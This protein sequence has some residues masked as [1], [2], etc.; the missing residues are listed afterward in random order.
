[1][2][3]ANWRI[4]GA[5]MAVSSGLVTIVLLACSGDDSGGPTGPDAASSQDSSTS[6]ASSR[7]TSTSEASSG[8]SASIQDVVVADSPADSAKSNDGS[9]EADASLPPIVPLA[10]CGILDTDWG[11]SPPVTND[12]RATPGGWD[13]SGAGGTVPFTLAEALTSDCEMYGLV[14]TFNPDAGYGAADYIDQVASFTVQFLGCGSAEAGSPSFTGL[15]PTTA[16]GTAYVWTRAD[17]DR[18]A[19]MYSNAIVEAASF[20]WTITDFNNGAPPSDVPLTDD[21]VS[22]INA[23]LAALEAQAIAAPTFT[24]DANSTKFTFSTCS[25]DAGSDAAAGD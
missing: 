11:L 1:M 16:L 14:A 24:Y 8:D 25:V 6:D 3:Q 5:A 9:A 18:L 15:M 10:L 21:Q 2:K 13:F 7:E 23:Q 20:G 17:L 19:A 22:A 12:D 4:R